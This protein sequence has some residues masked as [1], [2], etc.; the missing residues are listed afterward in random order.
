MGIYSRTIFLLLCCCLTATASVV[1]IT[2]LNELPLTHSEGSV[3]FFDIDD[4]LLDFP[5]MLGSKAWRKEMFQVAPDQHDRIVLFITKHIPATSVEPMTTQLIKELQ[6]KGYV[7]CGLTARERQVW[8][9]T[10]MEGVDILTLKQLT[11]AGIALDNNR[12]KEIYPELAKDAAYFEGV[13]FADISPKGDY[14]RKILEG[15][16]HR[17]KKIIFIDDKLRQV[18]SVDSVLQDLHIDHE[19]YWYVATEHQAAQFDPLIA[20]IQ[21]H[22]LWVSQGSEMLSD[23]EAEV[24]RLQHPEKTPDDY[25]QEIY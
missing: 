17:P 5:C 16:S 14:L 21:L 3:V 24:I 7:V 15:A 2:S 12:F 4:T 25:L 18:Q 13:F 11:S 10:P 20:A 6:T 22:H 23:Q 9:S 8:Y 1:K 19:C